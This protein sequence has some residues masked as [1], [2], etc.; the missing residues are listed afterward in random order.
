MTT[1]TT[2]DAL[3]LTFAELEDYTP[4]PA[5][6]RVVTKATWFLLFAMPAAAAFAGGVLLQKSRG[7]TTVATANSGETAPLLWAHRRRPLRARAVRRQRER[8]RER[9]PCRARPLQPAGKPQQP[10]AK[11]VRVARRQPGRSS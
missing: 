6:Q 2:P 8:E 11:A 10:A 4:P 9:Q 1:S 5:R 3:D 7:A